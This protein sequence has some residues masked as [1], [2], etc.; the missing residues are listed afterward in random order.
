MYFQI[1]IHTGNSVLH[2][3]WTP[4]N[5]LLYIS[6][7]SDW[8]NLYHVTSDN[9]HVNLHPVKTEIVK[10]HWIFAEYGYD[11]DPR[12]TGN[13]VTTFGGVSIKGQSK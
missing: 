3:R 10:P 6:D 8:W 7:E 13:I 4:N 12:G 9:Q 5:E 2:P 11:I 1:Q